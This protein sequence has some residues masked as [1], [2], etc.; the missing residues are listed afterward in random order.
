MILASVNLIVK[1]F[2]MLYLRLYNINCR[3]AFEWWIIKDLQQSICGLLRYY[4]GL[5]P[6]GVRKATRI[7]DTIATVLMEIWTEN[8]PCSASASYSGKLDRF[9]EQS[10]WN[11]KCTSNTEYF[12]FPNQQHHSSNSSYSFIHLKPYHIILPICCVLEFSTYRKSPTQSECNCRGFLLH[13]TVRNGVDRIS[14]TQRNSRK[15]RLCLNSVQC[16]V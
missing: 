4:F 11:L 1:S 14:N 3:I 6:D 9:P 16:F 13:Q 15:G 8:R 10:I 5:C 7:S 2:K 12:C